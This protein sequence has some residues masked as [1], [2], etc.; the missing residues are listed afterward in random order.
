MGRG[1]KWDPPVRILMR[2]QQLLEFKGLITKASQPDS[3]LLI[4]SCKQM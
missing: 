3:F 4:A 1:S 2:P